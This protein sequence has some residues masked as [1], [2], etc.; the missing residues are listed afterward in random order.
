LQ[1]L[2]FWV[3]CFFLVFTFLGVMLLLR[4]CYLLAFC[5]S[6]WGLPF[7]VSCFFGGF[8]FLGVMLLSRLYHSGCHTSLQALHLFFHVS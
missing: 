3:S 6:L 7:W 5:A 1:D 4:R 2:P 8:T